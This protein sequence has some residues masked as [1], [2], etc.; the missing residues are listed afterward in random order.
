MKKLNPTAHNPNPSVPVF[1]DISE[2]FFFFFFCPNGR[3]RL[4]PSAELPRENQTPAALHAQP[5]YRCPV[6][7]KLAPTAPGAGRG[8]TARSGVE[9][10]QDGNC[11]WE[12]SP[13]RVSTLAT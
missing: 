13:E 4:L 11:S 6:T 9:E 2:L 7:N 5:V 3:P 10:D 8:G 1:S 12:G